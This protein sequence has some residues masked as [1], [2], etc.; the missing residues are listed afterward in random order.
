MRVTS[1][2]CLLAF[3]TLMGMAVGL[4]ACGASGVA[5]APSA[6]LFTTTSP[7]AQPEALPPGASSTVAAPI[8]T[9][10]EPLPP[11]VVSPTASAPALLEARRL[12]LEF[13]YKI[14]VGD[15]DILR[16]T[17]EVDE[18]GGLTPTVEV[19]GHAVTGETVQIPNLYET[20]IVLAESRLDLA[21]ML[22]EPSGIQSDQLL[23]GRSVTFRW[24][25]H[26]VDAGRYRGAVHLH[27][28]FLPFSGGVESR[29]SVSSQ[30][31]E[32]QAV[33]FLGLSGGLA[34]IVGLL[35]SGMATVLGFPFIEDLLRWVW[36]RVRRK[37]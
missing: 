15:S 3:L 31:V 18:L 11:L 7:P 36:R 9:P 28:R 29:Q 20:H 5:P 14:R 2:F 37:A 27:L 23:P 6:P 13:P 30:V 4:S 8:G 24:S 32:I 26:P 21:G 16:L 19:A 10:S 17:L 33:K 12:T 35:G 34:R 1:L 25:L 22:V